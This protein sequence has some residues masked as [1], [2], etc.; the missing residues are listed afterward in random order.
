MRNAASVNT[1]V[2]SFVHFSSKL[3]RMSVRPYEEQP[4][5]TMLVSSELFKIIGLD[6]QPHEGNHPTSDTMSIATPFAVS[7][8]NL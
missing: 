6:S 3:E 2:E 4:K 5:S 8:D 1:L 7:A